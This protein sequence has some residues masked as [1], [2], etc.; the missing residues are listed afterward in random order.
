MDAIAAAC[1]DMLRTNIT[2]L[3]VTV[4]GLGDEALN[5]TPAPETNSIAVL[6][7]HAVSATRAL[8][9]S[10]LAGE[11]DRP[12]YLA[13]ERTPAF[14]TKDATEASLLALVDG[15][16]ATAERLET[17]PAAAYGETVAII[18]DPSA[19]VRSRAWNLIHAIEHL[20]EHIGHA[21]VTRQLWEAKG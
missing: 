6:V 3:R 5:W 2:D 8:I 15:L 4:T 21:Q 14:N 18:G 1:A 7:A 12:R 11:M 16:T 9:N 20:R 13:E 19:P 10:A 17:G